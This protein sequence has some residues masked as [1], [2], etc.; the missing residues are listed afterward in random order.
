[1]GPFG[2]TQSLELSSGRLLGEHSTL[3]EGLCHTGGHW[4]GMGMWALGGDGRL[5]IG[6]GWGRGSTC[7]VDSHHQDY[8]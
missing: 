2:P 7:L 1:M 4:E 5:G 3:E 6:R 8:V